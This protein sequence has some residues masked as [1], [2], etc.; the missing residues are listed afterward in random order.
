MTSPDG[1]TWT[2]QTSPSISPYTI[3]ES[4]NRIVA[5]GTANPFAM[6]SD[7]GI[8]WTATLS[9]IAAQC[10]GLS[11][12][13]EQALWITIT[14]GTGIVYQS[15]DGK[16]WTPTGFTTASSS[17]NS[18]KW[19]GGVVSRWYLAAFSAGG[20]HSLWSTPD[21]R[22]ANFVGCE[23]DGALPTGG[24]LQ[25]GL[26]YDRLR[27]RFLITYHT[28]PFVSVGTPRPSDIKAISDNIR[29]R[30]S[31]VA[32]GLYILTSQSTIQPL[33][34]ALRLLQAQLAACSYKHRSP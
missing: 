5:V 3:A 30:N 1:I 10:R 22:V 25:Y 18:L 24:G 32:V 26:L 15:T 19:A 27:G 20:N 28:S 33:R 34:R 13:P 11:Y 21:P 2:A 17:G 16:T 4:D 8:T 29:V 31:P 23:L 9:T 7:D 6:W 14:T 12:S